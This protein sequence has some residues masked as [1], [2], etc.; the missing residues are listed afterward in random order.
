MLTMPDGKKLPDLFSVDEE[1][2]L[3]FRDQYRVLVQGSPLR[4]RTD[5]EVFAFFDAFTKVLFYLFRAY[6]TTT[7]DRR[8]DECYAPVRRFLK[9]KE[10]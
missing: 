10:N 9:Y 8:G 2:N 1:G 3:V 4:R 5:A 7:P 6:L